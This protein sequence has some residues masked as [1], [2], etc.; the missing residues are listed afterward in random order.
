MAVLSKLK[1]A[2]TEKSSS[3]IIVFQSMNSFLYKHENLSRFELENTFDGLSLD[4]DLLFIKD[5]SPHLFYLERFQEIKSLVI[6]VARMYSQEFLQE[7]GQVFF[8][9]VL[10]RVIWLWQ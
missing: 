5:P 6:S 9:E 8:M 7:D 10:P 1:I 2:T 3:L 4:A